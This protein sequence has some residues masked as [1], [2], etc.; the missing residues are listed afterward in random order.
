MRVYADLQALLTPGSI[1]R[2]IGRYALE[3][4][5]A[6]ESAHPGAVN[7]WFLRP[8]LPVPLELTELMHTGRFRSRNDV[9]MPPPDVWHVLSPFELSDS[10][11]SLD[12]VWPAWARGSR[13]RLVVTLYDLIPLVYADKYL[14]DPNTRRAYLSRLQLIRRADKVFAISQA[15]AD[16]AIR[17]LGIP[18]DR[19]EVVGTG[20][21]EHFVPPADAAATLTRVVDEVPGLRPGYVLY[22][23]GIDFRKN[24]DGL[25][26]AYARLPRALRAEHQLVIVCRVLD[27][28]REHLE[29]RA[30]AL[31]VEDDFLLT[32]FLP[33][34]VLLRCYQAAH[35]F[36]FPS[37]YEG[38][39]LPVAEAL[40]CGVPTI[41]GR[42]S[43]LTEIVTDPAAWFDAHISDDITRA[44]F[45]SLTDDEL[46]ASLR[47]E[48]TAQDHR[49]AV[50]AERSLAAYDELPAPRPPDAR[51]HV[52]LVSPMPPAAS[53]VADY[54]WQL[55]RE[56][57][58]RA[59]VDVF[60]SQDAAHPPVLGVRWF[61][62]D[63]FERVRRLLG[64]YQDHVVALGNSE[65]H[66]ECVEILRAHGGTAI[67][68]DV[69]YTG[70]FSM[71]RVIAPHLMDD[72][73]EDTMVRLLAGRPP[74]RLSHLT[75][76][77]AR[78]YY[79]LNELLLD[80]VVATAH[81]V[82][83]HSRTAQ[84]L[85]RLNLPPA[86]R[87][88]VQ[89]IPFGMTV[90]AP[91]SPAHRDTIA[92]FGI[93]DSIKRSG[94]VADAFIALAGRYPDLHFALVGSC[95]DTALDADLH[96]RA[97]AAGLKERFT[98]T[99]RVDDGEYADWLARTR[100]A[101]QLR[102]HTNGESSA[103]VADCLGAGIP[104]IV[105]RLGAMAELGD[106]CV[107]VDAHCTVAEL[108]DAIAELLDDP[109]ALA[110]QGDRAFAAASTSTFGAAAAAILTR[111]LAGG[112]PSTVPQPRERARSAA[113]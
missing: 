11:R 73:S 54:S 111:S 71:A 75:T 107:Q 12:E 87:G 69:R 101:V 59:D 1:G 108:T 74:E 13:T 109:D 25:V 22:T 18:A 42:N 100:V 5:R 68:H 76:T 30:R 85:A 33:D 20:V 31:G 50:V 57:A 3:Y 58:E 77:A 49:W 24:I 79:R 103:A 82:L 93:V 44:L 70:L 60:T 102:A 96:A 7:G 23:G 47:R 9:D 10:G 26:T 27:S 91:S 46:R 65:H 39:G 64:G 110:E 52:A 32:G 16:D 2:G 35:L 14:A 113:S 28:E 45:R 29:Q 90:R 8:D 37:L 51:P 4:A 40:A 61:R 34:P 17:L 84:T 112:S 66:L 43:S 105:S 99:G 19:F 55:L 41:V 6:I 53:G 78:D 83:V 92:S 104:T 48:A 62:Y 81:T 95:L 89:Q 94:E 80:K 15:S 36:V 97:Q 21:S 67:I 98:L 88:K 106:A 63:Q 56:L 72:E 86:H 38:F